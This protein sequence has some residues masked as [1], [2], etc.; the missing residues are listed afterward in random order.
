MNNANIKAEIKNDRLQLSV[1]G[2]SFTLLSIA[3]YIAN[4]I[5]CTF[6]E[7]DQEKARGMYLSLLNDTLHLVQENKKCI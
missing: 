2:N 7:E 5:I 3:A 1:E 4:D 6:P